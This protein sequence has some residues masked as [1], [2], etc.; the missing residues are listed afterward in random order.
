[1]TDGYA[2]AP[3][4]PL[5]QLV[6]TCEVC[7]KP[8]ADGAGYLTVDWLAALDREQADY[9]RSRVS[10]EPDGARVVTLSSVALRA[11]VHWAVLHRKC[12]PRPKANDYWISVESCRTTRSLLRWTAHLHPKKWL[13]MTDWNELLWRVTA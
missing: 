4:P 11:P 12:D 10:D 5:T 13:G 8:I 9:A 2:V 3:R 1:M 7:K 6:W